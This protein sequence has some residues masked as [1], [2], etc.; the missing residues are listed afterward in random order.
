MMLNYIQLPL[1][2]DPAPLKTDLELI[3]AGE[4]TPHFNTDYFE[5]EW[6]VA[7]LRSIGGAINQIYPDPTKGDQFADT[8][9]LARCPNIRSVLSEFRCPLLSARLLKLAAGSVIREHKDY[10]LGYENG[11]IRLHLP[12]QTHPAVE[13][14]LAGERIV[15]NEGECWYL[16]FNL[17]HRVANP[18]PADRIHLVIDCVLD[19]WLRAQFPDVSVSE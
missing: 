12:V 4:W 7:P 13:F 17:P 18:S 6:S 10:N 19:D 2:F 16:N 14:H 9:L 5:G 11:E 15:M 8:E 1:N 3:A